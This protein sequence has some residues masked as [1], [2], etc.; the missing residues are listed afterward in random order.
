M[1]FM[2]S[3]LSLI[4]YATKE[5]FQM[6]MRTKTEKNFGYTP[7]CVCEQPNS[8]VVGCYMVYPIRTIQASM[9]IYSLATVLSMVCL[10]KNICVQ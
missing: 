7:V 2:L 8:F 4:L 10:L 6:Y 5:C 1:K 9:S 3:T